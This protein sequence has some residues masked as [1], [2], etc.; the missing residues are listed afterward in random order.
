MMNSEVLSVL[1][2]VRNQLGEKGSWLY[3]YVAWVVTQTDAPV[4][5]HIVT[6][7]TVLSTVVS[8]AVKAGFGAAEG[9]NVNIYGMLVGGSGRDRKSTSLGWG[10]KMLRAACADRVGPRL[11]SYE[12]LLD[13]LSEQP[14]CCVFEPEFSRFLSQSN[15]RSGGYLAA[16]KTGITDVYDGTPISRKTA[17]V[18][19]DI[20]THRLSFLGA[21]SGPYLSE[22]TEPEDFTGGFLSRWLFAYEDRTRLLLMPDSEARLKKQHQDLVDRLRSVYQ[23]SPAG[24]FDL[25]TEAMEFYKVWATSLDECSGRGEYKAVGLLER[26][27][28]LTRKIATLLAAVRLAEEEPVAAWSPFTAERSYEVS[29]ADLQQASWIVS[30]HISAGNRLV[31]TVEHSAA[32]RIKARVLESLD[33]MRLSSIGEITRK[34][35]TLRKQV[36]P[37]LETLELEGLVERV[38][39]SGKVGTCYLRTMGHTTEPSG[40]LP[41]GMPEIP[42]VPLR[43]DLAPPPEL[44]PL[45]F[46]PVPEEG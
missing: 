20:P 18:S 39:V 4:S 11:G 32:A 44:P 25:S 17:R 13:M 23:R 36:E 34:T 12:G 46:D 8:P 22:Y 19:V 15:G 29:L 33:T 14:T 40:D 5:Y 9:D 43:A 7:L 3:D 2:P 26:A 41:R 37:V 27:A 30:M 6:G 31:K 16:L 24:R 28:P 35:G 45:H 38:M 42:N 21:V 1:A 10:A